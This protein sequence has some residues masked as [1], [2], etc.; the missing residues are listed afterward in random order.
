MRGKTLVSGQELDGMTCKQRLTFKLGIVLANLK[1]NGIPA[2]I[3]IINALRNIFSISKEIRQ[4]AF[5]G[6]GPKTD[7]S[8]ITLIERRVETRDYSPRKRAQD[9]V[10]A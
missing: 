3:K 7:A 2:I 6:S 4:A 9:R 1:V 8:L 10:I 5:L